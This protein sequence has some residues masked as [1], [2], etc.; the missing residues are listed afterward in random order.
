MVVDD[1]ELDRLFHAL[2]DST[3][4]DVLRRSADGELS[5]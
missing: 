4:R 2:A 3:R 1:L 5:V